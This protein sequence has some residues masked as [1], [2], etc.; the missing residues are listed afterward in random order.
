[1]NKLLNSQYP[2]FCG[3]SAEANYV[4]DWNFMSM[5]ERRHKKCM[6]L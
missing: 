2:H 5:F 4:R 6:V 3:V 1:M